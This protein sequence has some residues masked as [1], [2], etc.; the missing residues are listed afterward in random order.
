MHKQ[1]YP[2]RLWQP[3]R[4]E[5]VQVP[6]KAGGVRRAV[7][8][9]NFDGAHRGHKALAAAARRFAGPEGEVVAL[10]FDPHPSL[11]FRPDQPH[12]RLT[13]PS[14][15]AQLLAA[16]G[17]D[18]ALVLPFNGTLAGMSATDFVERVLVRDLAAD[19][20]VVGADFHFGKGREGTPE[21]LR[22]AGER[23]GFAVILVPQ[24]RDEDGA[25]ISSSAIRKA[26][27]EGT[28]ERANALL[29][30]DFAISGTV[31]H[32]AKRGRELGYPTANVALPEGFGLRHGVYAVRVVVE[33]C[34]YMGAASFGTRPQ[35][36]NGAPLLETFLLD[37]SGDLY[38]KVIEVAFIAF[39][40][41]EAKFESLD[42]LIAQMHQDCE[43]A[44]EIL[45]SP[46]RA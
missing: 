25:V 6:G 24:V 3:A 43:K 9:G 40:R 23:L 28:V 11:F 32:G 13:Q 37:F 41:P 46:S 8:I 14:R 18:G 20:V 16:A 27:A 19:C 38:S 34:E 42:A 26:L 21:F 2:F 10:T 44:R 1:A 35:F 12:F 4:L 29:G 22:A 5:D 17:F 36:D 39:L 33:G 45:S 31:I 15:R 30:H 7:A